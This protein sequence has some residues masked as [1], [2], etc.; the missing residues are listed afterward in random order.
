MTGGGGEACLS[1][2]NLPGICGGKGTDGGH[3]EAGDAMV[4][5]EEFLFCVPLVG[6]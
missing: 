4:H 3:L 2:R 6:N 5:W 1:M